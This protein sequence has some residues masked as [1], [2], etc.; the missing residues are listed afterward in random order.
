VHRHRDNTRSLKRAVDAIRARGGFF[1]VAS[2]VMKKH[3]R[4]LRALADERDELPPDDADTG[5]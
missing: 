4:V 3:D 5:A 2:D 1:P